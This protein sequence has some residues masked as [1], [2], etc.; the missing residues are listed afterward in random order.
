MP[1]LLLDIALSA[2]RIKP[3]YQG[4]A[5]RVMATCRDGRTVSLPA[6]HLK[7][8]LTRDG[9]HGSFELEVS[10]AGKLLALRRVPAAP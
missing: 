10:D 2:E 6:H 1:V 7:P 3:L 8:F 9:I 5:N 4:H